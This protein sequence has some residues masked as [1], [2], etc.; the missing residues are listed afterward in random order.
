MKIDSRTGLQRKGPGMSPDRVIEDFDLTVPGVSL[1]FQLISQL[2]GYPGSGNNVVD[3][4]P[5]CYNG[6]FCHWPRPP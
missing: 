5:L 6:Y 3:S 2:N 1:F 4:S